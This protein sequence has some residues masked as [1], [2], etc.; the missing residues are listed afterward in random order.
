VQE[1]SSR[2]R[3]VQEISA[4]DAACRKFQPRTR[5]AGNF[6]RGRGVQEISSRGRGVQEIFSRGR[7]VQEIFAGQSAAASA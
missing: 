2:G 1:I 4:A 3:G 7:G 5:R 6:S